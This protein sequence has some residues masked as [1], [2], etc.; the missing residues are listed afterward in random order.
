MFSP[1]DNFK[2]DISD[3]TMQSPDPRK[4]IGLSREFCQSDIVQKPFQTDLC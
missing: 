3:I 2:S 4:R 1:T